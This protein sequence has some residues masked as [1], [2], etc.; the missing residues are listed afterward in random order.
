MTTTS[1]VKCDDIQESKKFGRQ[2]RGIVKTVRLHVDSNP[3]YL[4]VVV[5]Y[6]LA[7]QT[8]S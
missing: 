5:K 4:L 7:S 8:T 6:N 2:E 3:C 1:D